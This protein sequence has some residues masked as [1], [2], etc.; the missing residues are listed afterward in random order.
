[1]E[2]RIGAEPPVVILD[3]A[4]EE[5]LRDLDSYRAVGGY[6]QLERARAMTPQQ[7]TEALIQS[8][9]R[10]RG[11]AFFPTGRKASFIPTPDKVAKPIYLTVNADESEP[12]TFKDREIMLRVPHRLIEGCLI[13]AHAIQ[14]KH[15][16]IYIRGEY[17]TEYEVLGA[18][19]AEV[20]AAGLLADVELTIHRGAGAYICGEETA[21][22]ESLEGKRGQPRSKPPF[23]A[24]EGLYDSPTLINNVETITNVPKVLELGPEEY[25]QIGAPPDSTG[26]RV[27]CLSG[28][29][30][31]PG[32]YEAPHGI[33]VRHLIEDLG[34]GI[35]D[36][37][38]LKAVM[39]GGSSFPVMTADQ[40]DMRLD[41][42]S[43]AQKGLF[44]GSGV[45]TAIDDR[46][47]IVQFALRIAQ[48]YMHESCGKCTPCRVG[49]RWLVQ[50]VRSF[51]EGSA[52]EEDF[53]L[54]LDVC[55]RIIGKCLCVLGDSAA[56]PVASCVTKFRDEFRAHLEHGGCPFGED[57]SLAH[58]FAPSDQHHHNPV[59]QEAPV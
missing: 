54:L 56:M 28:N 44:I 42:D 18:A 39:V 25:A 52:S 41:V 32:A 46:T 4:L 24:I 3:G 43:L 1:M 38:Q 14:S 9:L 34:G 33:T 17:S 58:L 27:F 55:D 51:E 15:V 49:T 8:N 48:F 20:R 19:L 47:C 40:I 13:A 53:D 36:G 5:P 31:R 2:T 6:A 50:L 26:T 59:A 12:G 7:V 29:V 10:G 16:F 23:P 45:I 22:L 11:G 57:S 37:R 35:A 21:L 30:V